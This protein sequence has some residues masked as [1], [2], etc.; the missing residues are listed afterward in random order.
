MSF[1]LPTALVAV[2]ALLILLRF[3]KR[4]GIKHIRGPPSPSF[5]LGDS[6]APASLAYTL[7]PYRQV[8][9]P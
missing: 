1:A 9:K 7:T 3:F 4:S 5:I 8:M 6:Q 2:G